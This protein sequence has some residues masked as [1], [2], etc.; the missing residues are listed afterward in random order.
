MIH[1][2]KL[3]ILFIFYFAVFFCR[4]NYRC[5]FSNGVARRGHDKRLVVLAVL[6]SKFKSYARYEWGVYRALLE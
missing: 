2:F 6:N 5:F 1:L 3:V 4:V